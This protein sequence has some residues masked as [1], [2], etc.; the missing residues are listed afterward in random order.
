MNIV[1]TELPGVVI[2]EPKVLGDARGFFVETWQSR[3]YGE[4][5]L[6]T[7]MV[8]DN[9]SRS[10]QGVLRG[11]HYQW[12]YPQGKLAY[13]LEGE[14]VDVAVDIRLGS[15][16]FGRSVVV[17]LSGDDKRQ[18]YVPPGF[19]HGFYVSSPTA[20]FAYKC[21]EIYRPEF[22]RGVRWN[23][24]RLAIDWQAESPK[25]SDKDAVLPILAEISADL[26]PRYEG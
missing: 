18:V 3:R 26:L 14:V 17:K 5:G 4:A 1:R 9:V 8:Q 13:V 25:L 2:V 23:D 10:T 6:P 15:P 7:V 19:A 21:T 20:L 16:T 11:L 12:P 22:D 24:P